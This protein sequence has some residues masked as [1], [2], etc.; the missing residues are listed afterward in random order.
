M[1][2]YCKNTVWLDHNVIEYPQL[3]QI[4][5][6]NFLSFKM[7][8]RHNKVQNPWPIFFD[9]PCFELFW[10]SEVCKYQSLKSQ[11]LSSSQRTNYFKLK[12]RIDLYLPYV[13]VVVQMWVL[14]DIL[15]DKS[16]TTKTNHYSSEWKVKI[17]LIFFKLLGLRGQSPVEV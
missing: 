17:S 3:H 16:N 15:I 13:K 12:S 4:E 11:V 2:H 7:I 10:A 6:S 14:L 1:I 5:W 9:T 8:S